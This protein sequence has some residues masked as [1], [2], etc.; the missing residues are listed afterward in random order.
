MKRVAWAGL[1]VMFVQGIVACASGDAQTSGCDALAAC[2]ASLAGGVAETC[3]ATLSSSGASEAACSAALQTLENSGVCAAGRAD[4]GGGGAFGSDEGEGGSGCVALAACCP[5]LPVDADPTGCMAVAMDGTSEACTES[6]NDYEKSG[7]CV[8]NQ[9]IGPGS[10]P[11]PTCTS[12]GELVV[13]VTTAEDVPVC[14]ATVT[15]WQGEGTWDLTPSPPVGGACAYVGN[16]GESGLEIRIAVQAPG[17]SPG[18]STVT[19]GG[20]VAASVELEPEP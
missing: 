3:E 4:G 10:A 15:A 20:C 18:G 9:F 16:S 19:G 12:S 13:S 11:T 6:L 1:S 2:C 7:Y 17:Y 14:D 5:Q 8:Q